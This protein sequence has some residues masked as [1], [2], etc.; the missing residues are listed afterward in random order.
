MMVHIPQVRDGLQREFSKHELSCNVY[1]H[2][3][4]PR[5]GLRYLSIAKST[6]IVTRV[7]WEPD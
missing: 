5:Y 3:D 2:P 1:T 6:K 7:M 4:C